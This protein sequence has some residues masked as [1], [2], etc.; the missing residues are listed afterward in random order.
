MYIRP[1]RWSPGLQ[2]LVFWEASFLC[3]Q[4]LA[5]LS[6]GY[7]SSRDQ[8]KGEDNTFH[9]DPSPAYKVGFRNQGFSQGAGPYPTHL[10]QELIIG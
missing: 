9:V 10:S 7:L 8:G 4:P 2:L 3:F 1:V 6:Q 5:V